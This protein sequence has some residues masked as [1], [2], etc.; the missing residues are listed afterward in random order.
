[1][2]ADVS[3]VRTLGRLPAEAKLSGDVISPHLAAAGR[4]LTR[5]LGDYAATTGDDRE[6][7]KE[8][9]CCLCMYYLL[10]VLNTFYT[11]GMTT[12]Q[13]EIGE[14]DFLFH[15]P[16]DLETLKADWLDRAKEAVDHLMASADTPTSDWVVI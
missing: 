13:K 5:W 14:M 10:P 15:G 16:D 4:K 6:A 2:I 8:A 3:D 11:E 12:L 1:M 7:C 9:E